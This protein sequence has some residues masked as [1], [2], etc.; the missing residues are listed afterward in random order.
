VQ[1]AGGVFAI[2]DNDGALGAFND[3]AAEFDR[4]VDER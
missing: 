4:G 3:R 1:H 2:D